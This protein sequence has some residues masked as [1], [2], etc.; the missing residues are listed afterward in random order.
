MTATTDTSPDVI[1]PLKI[2]VVEDSIAY[3]TLVIAQMKRGLDVPQEVKHVIRVD[4]GVAALRS[5][6]FDLIILDMHLPDASGLD[7]F[8]AI[9][10]AGPDVPIVILSSDDTEELAMEAVR[11][12]AQDYLIKGADDI[13]KLMWSIKFAIERKKRLHAEGELQ[14]ARRIQ[15]SLLPESDP[16]MKGYDVHGAMFPAVETSGDYFDFIVP[17]PALGEDVNG[18][19]VGDVSGHGL[20]AAMVMAETR[21]CLNSFAMLESDLARL[22]QL[23]NQIIVRNRNDHLVTLLIGYID[24]EAKRFRYASAGHQGWHFSLTHGFTELGSTG[25]LLGA[26]L[27]ATWTTEESPPLSSGDFLMI[28]T[29]GITEATSESGEMFG[30]D[31]MFDFMRQHH[32]DS[33]KDLVRHLREHLHEFTGG[34]MQ[35]DDMTMVIV[36][37]TE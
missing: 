15:Q 22:L 20:G 19:A 14:A 9:N 5:G 30:T 21:G 33:A 28:V 35:E 31:R 34:A 36:K 2:L 3:A 7:T 26:S 18:I 27:S 11:R 37:V 4:E 16:V 23:T 10:G 24:R 8:T 13:N 6:S 25:M 32:D 29:D 12:G 1:D 17:I